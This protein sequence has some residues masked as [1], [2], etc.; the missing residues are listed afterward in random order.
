MFGKR[1]EK[2]RGNVREH[3]GENVSER[4]LEEFMERVRK[5]IGEKARGNPGANMFKQRAKGILREKAKAKTMT[6]HAIPVGGKDT[7]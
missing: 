4:V 1:I 3:V 7:E 6:S 5:R 2:V